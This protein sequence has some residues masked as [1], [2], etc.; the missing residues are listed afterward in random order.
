MTDYIIVG[1]G[2]AGICFAETALQNG[3]T[4]LVLMENKNLH[5]KWRQE[6]ITELH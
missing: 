1:A 3:K 2:L 6:F 4:I 5:L